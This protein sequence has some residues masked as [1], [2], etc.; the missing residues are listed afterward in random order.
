MGRLGS[1][2]VSRWLSGVELTSN[3]AGL[4]ASQDVKAGFAALNAAPPSR[5]RLPREDQLAELALYATSKEFG[6]LRRR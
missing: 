2:S 4:L 6:T 1:P 3:H 5:S